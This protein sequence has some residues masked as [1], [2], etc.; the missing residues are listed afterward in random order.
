MRVGFFVVLAL[1]AGLRI[2]ASQADPFCSTPLSDWQPQDA[3]QARLEADGWRAIRIRIE[4]GCYLVHAVN[5][6]G[7]RL[8]GKFDPGTLAPIPC[9]HGHH[10]HEGCPD[11]HPEE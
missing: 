5:D 8:H 11:N 9:G 4:D 6:Q 2:S 7:D 1:L 10:R 3:L